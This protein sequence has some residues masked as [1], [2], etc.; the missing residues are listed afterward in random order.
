MKKTNLLILGAGQYGAFVKELAQESGSY[1]LIDFL[2]DYN[3]G[4]IGKITDLESFSSNYGSALVAIGNTDIRLALFEKLCKNNY[5]VPSLVSPRAYV[6][7]SAVIG[8]GTIVEPMAVVQS[9]AKIGDCCLIASGAVVK[10]NAIVED[11][12]YIDCNSVVTA[13]EV[14]PF[15]TKKTIL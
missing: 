8:A 1:E 15:K 14:V 10:H 13:G 2:D 9:G 5:Y 3:L 6:S 4:A 11:G 12:C 7:P